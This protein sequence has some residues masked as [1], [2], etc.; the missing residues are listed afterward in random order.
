[1][2]A[3]QQRIRGGAVEIMQEEVQQCGDFNQINAFSS[4]L[5]D[6]R[7][8][9]ISTGEI[10][11]GDGVCMRGNCFSSDTIRKQ[12]LTNG[13]NDPLSREPFTMNLFGYEYHRD[14]VDTLRER[15]QE[16]QTTIEDNNYNIENLLDRITS[17][18]NTIADNRGDI[19]NLVGL[20]F[21]KDNLIRELI[22][23]RNYYQNLDRIN[24]PWNPN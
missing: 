5:C 12:I 24:S 22:L 4:D 19:A 6:G 7:V 16:A 20:I 8:D 2:G 14:L 1:M 15:L 3:N 17:A 10:E 23:E 11:N 9:P 21:E 13:F 18:D